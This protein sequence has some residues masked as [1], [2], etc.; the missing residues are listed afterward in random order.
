VGSSVGRARRARAQRRDRLTKRGPANGARWRVRGP[1]A[2]VTIRAA[3]RGRASVRSPSLPSLRTDLHAPSAPAAA[4]LRLLS[5]TE[6]RAATQCAIRSRN[7][8]PSDTVGRRFSFHGPMREAQLSAH[9]LPA[10][11]FVPF[12]TNAVNVMA[13]RTPVPVHVPPMAADMGMCA[14]I[15]M[16]RRLP[17]FV[18]VALVVLSKGRRRAHQSA[19]N[20]N[21]NDSA[22]LHLPQ[23]ERIFN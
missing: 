13:G 7:C 9:P 17:V 21:K 16:W 2:A 18:H 3:G 4:L 22:H 12:V 19:R 1:N 8:A 23:R 20:N 11:Q 14:H 5:Q 10:E 15:F 6:E